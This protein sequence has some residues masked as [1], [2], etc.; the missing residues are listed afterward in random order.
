M[1]IYSFK[2]R[3]EGDYWL[4]SLLPVMI[5]YI[6]NSIFF[7]NPW[8]RANIQPVTQIL[9]TVYVVILS[10][11]NILRGHLREGNRLLIYSMLI[12]L[13][14]NLC[15]YFIT[16]DGDFFA[17]TLVCMPLI[18]FLAF[19]IPR[20]DIDRVQRLKDI[21]FVIYI[22][23]CL[24]TLWGIINL[25]E[26]LFAGEMSNIIDG[27]N[28]LWGYSNHPNEL[29]FIASIAAF[30]C[31]YTLITIKE[32]KLKI[33]FSVFFFINFFTLLLTK[34][35]SS[36]IFLLVALL[37]VLL[38]LAYKKLSSRQFLFAL[39]FMILIFVMGCSFIIFSRGVKDGVSLYDLINSISSGRIDLYVD[40]LKAG[41]DSPIYGNSYSYLSEIYYPVHMAHNLYIDLFA[42]YG[43]FSLLA[44]F[45]FIGGLIVYSICL[46]KKSSK[47]RFESAE[48]MLFIFC[49]ALI[50]G[51]AV[52]HLFDIFIFFSGYSAGN[53]FFIICSGYLAYH[54]SKADFKLNKR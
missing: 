29:G 18:N 48:Y 46:I 5:I 41:I 43:F 28:R 13:L 42:R 25:I 33:C 10:L 8:F 39:L 50:V 40:G 2:K 9:M 35:R 15:S 47:Y 22:F 53:V 12:F 26:M 6:V 45:I 54:I 11:Y 49:F 20:I 36:E 31:I 3:L 52:Q 24:A 37:G 51:F 16:Y 30:F 4:N 19:G 14:I 21:R 38:I 34:S 17:L 23:C 32:I 1:N 27:N 44:F 7:D